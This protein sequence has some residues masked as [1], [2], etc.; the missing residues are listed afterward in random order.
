MSSRTL[1]NPKI[2]LLEQDIDKNRLK[3]A[4]DDM[5][6]N[7]LKYHKKYFPQGTVLGYLALAESEFKNIT[8][9]IDY[10][11]GVYLPKNPPDF[12]RILVLLNQAISTNAETPNEMYFSQANV[13]LAYIQVLKYD[14]KSALNTLEKINHQA[15]LD[16][17]KELDITFGSTALIM[18]YTVYGWVYDQTHQQIEAMSMLDN[19]I[20]FILKNLTNYDTWTV[21]HD[22]VEICIHTYSIF[23]TSNYHHEKALE[24]I[25]IF[26][27]RL[28]GPNY[29][30]SQLRKASLLYHYISLLIQ[31]LQEPSPF[32]NI[33]NF[34]LNGQRLSPD[35]Y[36]V[37]QAIQIW[38][39]I[40]EK[41]VTGIYTFP[42]G[43]NQ[44]EASKTRYERVLKAFDWW[45]FA[46]M[47]E[48][49]A[50][51]DGH[52]DFLDKHYR[53]LEVLYRG[54][55][56]SFHSLRILRY[57][58]HTF[59]SLIHHFGDNIGR[60]EKR[61][62]KCIL[63]TY[64]FHW[65][66]QFTLLLDMET[67]A[68]QAKTN[69]RNTK[70]FQSHRLSGQ[71]TQL[72]DTPYAPDIDIPDITED[73]EIKDF[74]AV[75]PGDLKQNS[76]LMMQE[77]V[78]DPMPRYSVVGGDIRMRR[79]SSIAL[80]T[81]DIVVISE[82][83]G[84]TVPDVLGVLLMG[85]QLLLLENE[86]DIAE[87][88][89]A[90]EYG[91]KAFIIITEHGSS[92]SNCIT[93]QSLV[94]QWLGVVYGELAVEVFDRQER[95]DFQ[96]EAISLLTKAK[97]LTPNNA[98]VRYQLALQL[99]EVGEFSL[100]IDEVN[101][102]IQLDPHNPS[103]YNLLALLLTSKLDYAKALQV[104]SLGHKEF[105]ASAATLPNPNKIEL[106]Y[107]VN[108]DNVELKRKEELLN[109]RLTELSL[110]MQIYGPEV[111]LEQLQKVFSLLRRVVG[112]P[113]DELKR[114]DDKLNL[115]HDA[116]RISVSG[117][118]R[119]FSANN[120]VNQSGKPINIPK[121]SSA[122][123]IPVFHHLQMY[124]IQITLWL[125]LSSI[126][127]ELKSFDQA[128]IAVDE[129]E[130]ILTNLCSVQSR[131]RYQASRLFRDSSLSSGSA[132]G[133]SRL[134][135]APESK[136][137]LMAT[138][139]HWKENDPIV[140]KIQADIAL[141]RAF[142]Q[143]ASY[144]YQNITKTPDKYMKYLS[145][146]TRVEVER[147]AIQRQQN[148]FP[149]F[150]S[151]ASVDSISISMTENGTM[152]PTEVWV[153]PPAT[154]SASNLMSFRLPSA[155]N[156]AKEPQMFIKLEDIIAST[157]LALLFDKHNL[158]ARVFLG[159]LLRENGKLE[160]SEYHLQL[161]CTRQSRRASSSGKSGIPSIYGG[162]TSKW[163]WYSWNL[164]AITLQDQ[165]RL[166]DA[167]KA[168]LYSASLQ[169]I[170]CIRGYECLARF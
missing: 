93:L 138:G 91:E 63:A 70:P 130:K 92:L 104:A 144:K 61:E 96:N 149:R 23:L 107:L 102:S 74:V 9:S 4:Y 103:S 26:V 147:K 7:A 57:I 28:L 121:S 169:S 135:R 17:T 78:S 162:A 73:A 27:E 48:P 35:K 86:G 16:A 5:N 152:A 8:L 52:G 12:D 65:E 141:E 20:E 146:I 136:T 77:F 13:L 143:L 114:D 85:M 140:S 46:E 10:D 82:V 156:V 110:E 55:T 30:G 88:K 50:V 163:G 134:A 90:A 15:M 19:A 69:K 145:P 161:A 45:V 167:E 76:Q 31:K 3:R 155:T 115:K 170:S 56:H 158:P 137:K 71:I 60:D 131:I 106:E 21:Y 127:R 100:A 62:A 129:A 148:R 151:N 159:Y 95:E 24:V 80:A 51:E 133:I 34:D 132:S 111:V 53:L 6:A 123:Q 33:P 29:N 165:G 66:K 126:Y 32:S 116:R 120:I 168:I 97:Q 14:P 39:P 109:L 41:V 83:Q 67:K 94:Y 22:W 153:N 154:L 79:E 89:L 11:L 40:Y 84:E 37:L 36:H 98:K 164:L 157:Q 128:S 64:V 105:V 42:E 49:K 75:L 112:V 38:I 160:E 47:A 2:G 43:E 25:S 68:K 87:L 122:T 18:Y 117:V 124:D 139:V 113:P 59:F 99:S 58:F 150:T 101:K 119:R 166:V 118:E 142:I 54:T 108:W 72:F 44:T 1:R 125:T 81:A